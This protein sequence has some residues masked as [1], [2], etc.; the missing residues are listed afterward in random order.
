M[1]PILDIQN[2]KVHFKTDAGT[3]RAVDGVDLQVNAGETLGLVGESGCGKSVTS[4][5]MMRLLS[6]KT[7]ITGK[8]FFSG[9][10][11][12]EKSERE[13]QAIRGNKISMI[14]QDPMTSLNPVLTIAEQIEEVIKYH[15]GGTRKDIQARAVEMM[16]L[17]KIPDGERRIHEYPHQMSGGIR[18]RIMIAMALAC[19]PE[20]LIADEPTTA[21]DVTVQAQILALIRELQVQFKTAVLLITHDL[22]VVAQVADKIAVMYAGQIVEYASAKELFYSPKHPYTKGLLDTIPRIDREDKEL[23]EI[24]GMVPD[25][26]QDFKGCRF[27]PR[28]PKATDQCCRK[29]IEL[30]EI[31]KTRVRCLLYSDRS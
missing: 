5:S 10:N 15:Q 20:M 2:L 11:I 18:Q 30:I 17:V 25:L 13:M 4:L 27:Y 7:D 23:K 6:E 22:G 26:S 8:I 31:G 24:K 16:D 29:E 21:L 28:C 14:F 1:K 9:E 3:V 12:L 19:K